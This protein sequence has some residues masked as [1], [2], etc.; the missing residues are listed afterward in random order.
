[1]KQDSPETKSTYIEA[2]DFFIKTLF[3][4]GGIPIP[5][6][7]SGESHGQRGIAG[8]GVTES[9]TQLSKTRIAD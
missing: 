5:V 7:L 1:M 3:C 2:V 4:V 8:H 6:F 9:H